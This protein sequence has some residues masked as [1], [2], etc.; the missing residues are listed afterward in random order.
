[1]TH[2]VTS[3]TLQQTLADYERRLQDQERRPILPTLVT[4]LPENSVDGQE[5]IYVADAAN[6]VVWRFRYR[7]AS[8]STHKWEFV[9]GSSLNMGV[10]GGN[11]WTPAHI[12]EA[13]IIPSGPSIT[14]PLAG[15]YDFTAGSMAVKMKENAFLRICFCVAAKSTVGLL[16]GVAS[17]DDISA[18]VQIPHFLQERVTGL[19]ASTNVKL[20]TFVSSIQGLRFYSSEMWAQPVRVG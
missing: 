10:K 17:Q 2:V 18:G 11:E 4:A 15:D 1:M 6:G 7:E 16:E 14:V 8:S 5:I 20:G 12:N 9:G 19:S 13:E 3:D